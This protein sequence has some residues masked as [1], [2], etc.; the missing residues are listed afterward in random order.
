M[1]YMRGLF[2]LSHVKNQ[3]AHVSNYINIA[4]NQKISLCAWCLRNCPNKIIVY[5]RRI[6]NQYVLSSDLCG[7]HLVLLGLNSL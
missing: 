1:K 4:Q 3:V 5:L 6:V 2:F 7:A